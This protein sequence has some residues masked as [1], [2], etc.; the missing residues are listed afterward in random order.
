MIPFEDAICT[1]LDAANVGVYDTDSG[2]NIF[3]AVLPPEPNNCIA[4]IGLDG[5]IIGE[6]RDVADLIFPRF[7]IIVRNEDFD[8][9]AAKL[10]EVRDTLHGMINVFL[11]DDSAPYWRVLRCHAYQEGGSIGNDDQGR[12]EFS[13]N[14]AAETHYQAS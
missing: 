8:T 13:I 4:L 3:K 14:F 7:Q 9:G 5:N 10:K 2:R 6:N 11:P 1:Y 12:F